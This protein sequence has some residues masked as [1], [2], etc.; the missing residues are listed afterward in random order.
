VTE[1]LLE[2]CRRPDRTRIA[3]Q[4]HRHHHSGCNL[5]DIQLSPAARVE[6]AVEKSLP[7]VFHDPFPLFDFLT[8]PPPVEPDSAA[9][10]VRPD[11][12]LDTVS[13]AHAI[14]CASDSEILRRV[15]RLL[16]ER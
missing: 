14:L 4:D 5:G 7:K 6:R 15:N 9:A 12:V 1:L 10:M 3:N 8:W 13:G 16:R 2:D 11:S